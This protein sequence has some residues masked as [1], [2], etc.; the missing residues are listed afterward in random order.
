MKTIL[1][2]GIHKQVVGLWTSALN[3]KVFPVSHKEEDGW[4]QTT[5]APFP[6]SP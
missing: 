4:Y 2:L 1:N 5:G 6:L 3:F